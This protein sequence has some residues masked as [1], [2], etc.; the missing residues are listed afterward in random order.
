MINDI[1]LTVPDKKT[2]TINGRWDEKIR[3]S[4]LHLDVTDGHDNLTID[5]LVNIT[6]SLTFE[7]T[8]KNTK[9]TEKNFN[10]RYTINKT[11]DGEFSPRKLE[12]TH[13]NDPVK[14]NLTITCTYLDTR[15]KFKNYFLYAISYPLIEAKT[16][17]S[18]IDLP[19]TYR[20]ELKIKYKQLDV[21]IEIANEYHKKIHGD[22]DFKFD[23][24][25]FSNKFQL[26]AKKDVVDYE[27]SKIDHS[28]RLNDK[29]I[30]VGGDIKYVRR[31]K[32][33]DSNAD[34]NVK[35]SGHPNTIK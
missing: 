23:L 30:E 1:K 33:L 12:L 19:K 21:G 5:A 35:I 34:L 22:Y 17:F 24:Y 14:N 4:K 15:T 9:N 20:R 13:G 27:R 25:G 31:R 2:F 10:L 7:L 18:Y 11:D 28:I 26:K 6:S 29:T 3:T 16:S 8:S 32:Y